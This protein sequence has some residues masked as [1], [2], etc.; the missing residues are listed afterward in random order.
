M[1]LSPMKLLVYHKRRYMP[2]CASGTRPGIAHDFIRCFSIILRH[3][4]Y[5]HPNTHTH[6]CRYESGAS[7][8]FR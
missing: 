7:L 4:R 2:I 6:D 3:D 8:D 5:V 1:C